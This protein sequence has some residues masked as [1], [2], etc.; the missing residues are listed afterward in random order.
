MYYYDISTCSQGKGFITHADR[1]AIP[2]ITIDGS[3]AVMD[4]DLRDL[5]PWSAR[6]GAVR[7]SDAQVFEY[8][9]GRLVN[10][11]DG[12]AKA[13]RDS[14]VSH[15]SPAEMASWPIKRAE[16]LAY[17]VSGIVSDALNLSLEAQ[18]RG[19]TLDAL[20]SKVLVKA[21]QLA[22]LEAAIAG[23]CGAIQDTAAAA[24]T[25]ADIEGIDPTVGWPV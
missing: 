24:T 12:L 11:A 17:Q 3:V 6:V 1:L 18:A 19:V 13:K 15:I 22:A 4:G 10:A 25:L 2:G 20:A 14:V 5:D 7:L 21:T 16:A 23:R 8:V 9:R